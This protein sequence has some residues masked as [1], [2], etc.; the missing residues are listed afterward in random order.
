MKNFSAHVTD[1]TDECSPASK[2]WY[3]VTAE[4]EVGVK[5]QVREFAACAFFAV[6]RAYYRA[7][8]VWEKSGPS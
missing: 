2:V 3:T 6:S 7:P 8:E 4:D 5:Y 1:P